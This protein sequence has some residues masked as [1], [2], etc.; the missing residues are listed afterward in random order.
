MTHSLQSITL[1]GFQVFDTPVE[2]PLGKISFLFGPN[3]AG[4][5]ALSDA[6]DIF[7]LLEPYFDIIPAEDVSKIIRRHYRSSDAGDLCET[8]LISV[9]HEQFC[10]VDYSLCDTLG[11]A[12]LAN[13]Q[14]YG[15]DGFVQENRWHIRAWTEDELEDTGVTW[16][17]DVDHEIHLNGLP[18]IKMH[19]FD[20]AKSSCTHLE[21]FHTH[22]CVD[23]LLVNRWVDL[24]TLATNPV[25][26]TVSESSVQVRGSYIY[27]SYGMAE[28]AFNEYIYTMNKSPLP[29]EEWEFAYGSWMSLVNA[30]LGCVSLGN[31]A[32]RHEIVRASRK[33]PSPSEVTFFPVKLL[34][35]LNVISPEVNSDPFYILLMQSL[36]MQ[37]GL[38][39]PTRPSPFLPKVS[40]EIAMRVNDALSG[41]LFIEKGYQVKFESVAT[42]VVNDDR[43]ATVAGLEPG[44]ER[45]ELSNGIT[46]LHLADAAMRRIEIEDV[47]SGI[48][49]VI[50]A[51]VSLCS[52]F[53]NTSIIQQ[54]ELHLHP[55]LQ[56]AVGDVVIEAVG[57]GKQTVIETHSEHLLLRIL[58]RIRQR[59]SGRYAAEEVALDADDVCVLYFLPQLDGTTAVKRL[60]LNQ[61]G[62][63]I[64]RWPNGFF[65]ERDDELFDE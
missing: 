52:D 12:A 10:R 9:K 13:D 43:V 58:K 7:S 26:C 51:L 5:S 56:A 28:Q 4:K 55:A 14:S 49:Y 18:F 33:V 59:A 37:C 48:G 25:R 22:P 42:I 20:A 21:F 27:Q 61:A 19:G 32:V 31:S 40:A 45:T 46:R 36:A 34:S 17:V 38:A 60:R 3:S 8:M 53:A 64:D 47:G 35:A 11:E 24:A 6:L 1:G 57:R 65:S 39:P 50:P 30:A 63:F 23:P 44:Q 2:I 54:P 62:E 41:H 29:S 15:W 16:E